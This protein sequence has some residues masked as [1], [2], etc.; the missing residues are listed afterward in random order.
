MS[1][2]A[3]FLEALKVNPADDTARLVYADWLDEHNQPQKAE[4]LRLTARLSQAGDG[5]DLSS[6]DATRAC[7]LG[8]ALPAEWKEAAAGRFDVVLLSFKDKVR[9]VKYVREV[10]GV[11]LGVAKEI[12]EG[13]PNRLIVRV[14]FDTAV[15][16]LSRLVDDTGMSLVV[17]PYEQLS[18]LPAVLFQVIAKIRLRHSSHEP[19]RRWGDDPKR[20]EDGLA[21]LARFVSEALGIDQADASARVQAAAFEPEQWDSDRCFVL[22]DDIPLPEA[23]RLVARSRPFFVDSSIFS[24]DCSLTGRVYYP[25]L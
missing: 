1:D 6:A 2:E 5:V 11:G 10:C 24:V 16:L 15:P 12:V 23:Q 14:P 13:A 18:Q 4:Y 25:S 17:R 22:A 3:A 7:E 20:D 21:A 9:G 19:E 8:A